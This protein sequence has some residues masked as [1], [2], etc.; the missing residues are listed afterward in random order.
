M[1]P[2]LE[3]VKAKKPVP[4]SDLPLPCPGVEVP[5]EPRKGTME[6]EDDRTET[7]GQLGE[8]R[9][10]HGGGGTSLISRPAEFP[11]AP[12]AVQGLWTIL[13]SQK[14]ARERPPK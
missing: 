11:L 1:H 13:G 4:A 9:D 14:T 3:V 5:K 2:L 8:N 6:E 7:K 10:P 12:S